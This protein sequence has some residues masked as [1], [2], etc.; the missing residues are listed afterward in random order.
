MA[1]LYRLDDV[2]EQ[3]LWHCSLLSL[4]QLL[5]V[6]AGSNSSQIHS[7][8]SQL[9]AMVLQWSRPA[10][11]GSIQLL[12]RAMFCSP[13]GSAGAG[14]AVGWRGAGSRED[15][16]GLQELMAPQLLQLSCSILEGV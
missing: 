14:S 10:I 7:A 4:S 6:K 16:P 8:P 11:P 1:L 12:D 9:A 5:V 3:F 2:K 15:S 13:S